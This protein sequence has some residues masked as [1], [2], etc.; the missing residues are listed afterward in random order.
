MKTTP[1]TPGRIANRHAKRGRPFGSKNSTQKAVL[2]RR[3]Y[4]AFTIRV[5]QA[6]YDKV[7]ASALENK[8]SIASE[9]ELVLEK[10]Y[11]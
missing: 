1:V 5:P 9:M 8:R 10:T 11:V 2:I 3:D 7:L 4:R 6:L